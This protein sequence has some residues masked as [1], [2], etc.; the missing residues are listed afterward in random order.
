MAI[1]FAFMQ[2]IAFFIEK[3]HFWGIL[4]FLEQ[5]R[6][7]C[8]CPSKARVK[9]DSGSN[10]SMLARFEEKDPIF[11]NN[12]MLSKAKKWSQGK[13]HPYR[14]SLLCPTIHSILKIYLMDHQKRLGVNPPEGVTPKKV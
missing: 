3:S 5:I 7:M 14:D 8:Y 9:L 2:K 13:Q 6:V 1:N 4:S 10:P 12:A 11:L